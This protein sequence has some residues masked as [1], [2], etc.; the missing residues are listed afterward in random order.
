MS[1]TPDY[2]TIVAW[3]KG[4]KRRSNPATNMVLAV[5]AVL[6]PVLL[7]AIAAL[8][9]AFP[10]DGSDLE[11]FGLVIAAPT[12]DV[13]SFIAAAL[14]LLFS[15]RALPSV[16]DWR[17]KPRRRYRLAAIQIITDLRNRDLID[18]QDQS[19]LMSIAGSRLDATDEPNYQG[20]SEE[21]LSLACSEMAKVMREK[22]AGLPAA[23]L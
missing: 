17:T 8:N 21:L 23:Q 3:R 1:N 9:I 11:V 22:A 7:I 2:S 4:V 16:R 6:T 12:K 14:G 10:K 13:L 20:D 5:L 15:L 18:D 19:S